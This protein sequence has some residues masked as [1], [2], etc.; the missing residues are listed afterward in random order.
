MPRARK[1]PGGPKRSV[2]GQS[3]TNKFASAPKGSSG[4]PRTKSNMNGRTKGK[5]GG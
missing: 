5:Y 4:S 3:G 1:G 2:A